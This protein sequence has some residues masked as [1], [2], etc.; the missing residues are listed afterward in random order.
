VILVA[1]WVG[2]SVRSLSLVFLGAQQTYFFL[3]LHLQQSLKPLPLAAAVFFSM[4]ESS[5]QRTKRER[6]R[7]RKIERE[8]ERER[9]KER[10]RER[11][12]VKERERER[13]E[14]GGRRPF[15]WRLL[16]LGC[17]RIYITR[18]ARVPYAYKDW[19]A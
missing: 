5:R 8:G 10:E 14:K 2:R 6:K 4:L 1:E 3:S 13:E 12:R 16:R 7:E 17:R 9:V 15:R 19:W 18:S 11:E